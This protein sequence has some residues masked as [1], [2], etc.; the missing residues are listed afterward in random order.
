MSHSGRHLGGLTKPH[1][2]HSLGLFP[3]LH[4][5]EGP[6]GIGSFCDV[7][8]FFEGTVKFVDLAMICVADL[9]HVM[10]PATMSTSSCTMAE[11]TASSMFNAMLRFFATVFWQ[12]SE[13][14]AKHD[15]PFL[16]IRRNRALDKTA[17]KA[18]PVHLT[19]R[20]GSKVC[21]WNKVAQT[22]K[23]ATWNWR[24]MSS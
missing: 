22:R 11:Q 23:C 17:S 21:L 2:F 12:C 15:V 3:G 14:I 7:E 18:Q 8:R 20:S 16:G 1:T 9:H 5:G 10:S 24:V 6:S 19:S 4:K 13:I